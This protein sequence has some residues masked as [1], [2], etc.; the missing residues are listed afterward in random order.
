[1]LESTSNRAISLPAGISE[2]QKE[3]ASFAY[4]IPFVTLIGGLPL[5]IVNLLVSVGYLWHVR[6]KPPFVRFHAMQSLLTTLP[7][8]LI[9][10]GLVAIT[11]SVLWMGVKFQPWH[12]GY[13]LAA[14]LFNLVEFVFNIYAAIH[15]RRGEMF[16]FWGF[17]ELAH[18]SVDW[19]APVHEG[20]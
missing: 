8:V 9:N 20:L 12:G 19:E 11:V 14:V 1:M 15:A 18:D 13:L 6:R 2:R 5:P 16:F 17:G 4:L 10:A 3:E 7:V